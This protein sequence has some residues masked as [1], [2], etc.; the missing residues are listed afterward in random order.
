MLLRRVLST[1]LRWMRLLFVQRQPMLLAR[2]CWSCYDVQPA[3]RLAGQ[4][5]WAKMSRARVCF[6]LPQAP[7][8]PQVLSAR[9]WPLVFEPATWIASARQRSKSPRRLDSPARSER[10]KEQLPLPSSPRPAATWPVLA[11]SRRELASVPT[12]AEAR[13]AVRVAAKSRGHS[14]RGSALAELPRD[15]PAGWPLSVVWRSC[16]SARPLVVAFGARHLA[17]RWNQLAFVGQLAEWRC[18]EAWS[19]SPPLQSAESVAP[20]D[21]RVRCAAVRLVQWRRGPSSPDWLGLRWLGVAPANLA[22]RRSTVVA[23]AATLAAVVRHA[24]WAEAE[25]WP[26]AYSTET[27]VPPDAGPS[28]QVLVAESR[29][30]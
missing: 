20:L 5:L 13:L 29:S 14:Q 30:A 8:R 28:R 27:S 15:L 7:L 2:C 22:T 19:G 4:Q 26:S 23:F 24:D 17:E 21:E 11:D 18:Y 12:W 16:C 6:V 1:A 25:S 9:P 3:I 10:V